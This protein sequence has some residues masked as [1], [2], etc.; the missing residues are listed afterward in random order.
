MFFLPP[1]HWE[2]LEHVLPFQ[3]TLPTQR[4]FLRWMGSDSSPLRKR[5]GAA[6][7]EGSSKRMR[8]TAEYVADDH[9]QMQLQRGRCVLRRLERRGCLS[10][11]HPQALRQ[12]HLC[13]PN[14]V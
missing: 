8:T 11:R 6:Q 13:R 2:R 12:A 7:T 14:P 10:L 4:N 9:T 5:V 3:L 1:Q